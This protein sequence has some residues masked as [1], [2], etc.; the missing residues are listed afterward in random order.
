M[1]AL[2][3]FCISLLSLLLFLSLSV[4]GLALTLNSTILNSDFIISEIDELDV[5][6]LAKEFLS[7]EVPE[8]DL[9]EELRIALNDIIIESEPAVKEQIYATIYPIFD[10]LLGKSQN[11]GLLLTLENTI[12]DPDFVISLVDE[13]DI[14][15][16]AEEFI[17]EQVTERI[18]EEIEYLIEYVDDVIPKVEPWVKEQVRVAIY[19]V[20]DYLL[21]ESQS[22][23]VVISLEPVLES[24]EEIFKEAFLESPPPDLTHLTPTEIEQYFK[25]YFAE[26]AEKMSSTFEIDEDLLGTEIPTQIAEVLAEVEETLE[27]ARQYVGY[28]QLGYKLVIGFIP[29][30][31][32][33]IILMNRQVKGATRKI[34]II[35]LCYGVLWYVGTFIFKNFARAQ[36]TQLDIPVQFQTLLPPLLSDILAPLG[37]F[38]IG[39]LIAGV[40][41]IVVSFVY[42]PRQRF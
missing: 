22:L 40:V 24:L 1:K 13:L 16:L 14:S 18:P 31:I 20:L 41:L 27:E 33:G 10:Y 35:F 7:E 21:G 17:T 2:K 37:M 23:N 30:L 12:L 42:K 39:L 32:L 9:S 29:L 6:S 34:G 3:I 25:E 15:P 19:P 36:I 5:A 28:F 4:F 8:E 38:C 11:L 26:L